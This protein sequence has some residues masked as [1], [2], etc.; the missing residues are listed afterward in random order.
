VLKAAASLETA[1]V[2]ARERFERNINSQR[3]AYIRAAVAE[4]K[5][6]LARLK[7]KHKL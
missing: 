7:R 5:A 3:N 4:K 2:Q 6:A 1:E